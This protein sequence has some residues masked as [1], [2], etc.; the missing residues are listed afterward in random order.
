MALPTNLWL[1]MNISPHNTRQDYLDFWGD[2]QDVTQGSVYF[3]TQHY[4]ANTRQ[5]YADENPTF[6]AL[7]ARDS[8]LAH[9]VDQLIDSVDADFLA[10]DIANDADLWL[11]KS[12]A[13]SILAETSSGDASIA[14]W[15][16][17]DAYFDLRV[18]S[19]TSGYQNLR[20]TNH[21][22]SFT[23]Q[24]RSDD[25]STL[26]STPLYMD[27]NSEFTIVLGTLFSSGSVRDLG[28]VSYNWH[29][30]Y[31]S[32][33]VYGSLVPSSTL[34]Y[35]LGSFT[36]EWGIA[37][38]GN[39]YISNHV[40]GNLVPD[41]TTAFNLGDATHLWLN[42]YIQDLQISGDVY[43]DLIPNASA[44]YNLGNA[45]RFWSGAYIN[46][47]NLGNLITGHLTPSVPSTYNI[48]T[49]T[50]IWD[51]CHVNDL[52]V[53]TEVFTHLYPNGGSYSLGDATRQWFEVH[54]R[55]L[56]IYNLVVGN[57]NPSSTSYDLG[58]STYHWGEAHVED[59]YFYNEIYGDIIPHNS[60]SQYL[61]GS[62]H[63]WADI[64]TYRLYAYRLDSP[65]GTIR[66]E[67]VILEPYADNDSRLGTSG[68]RFFACYSSAY[69]SFTG[70]HDVALGDTVK[71][72]KIEEGMI[73]SS[74]GKVHVEDISNTVVEVDISK[75]PNDPCV[76]GVFKSKV[77]DLEET[78]ENKDS[79]MVKLAKTKQIWTV[80]SVGE[81]G[82]L[83]I[84]TEDKKPKNGD[85]L[86]TSSIPGYATV[87]ED[88]IFKSCTIAKVTQDIDW[89][90][91]DEYVTHKRK[92]YKKA[93]IAVTYHCG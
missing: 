72:K 21:S 55:N 47:L 37:Y 59:V 15:G 53:H 39:L 16:T 29:D 73:A 49:G 6:R 30:F 57:L 36:N 83:V 43:G 10:K 52:Y 79:F 32:G 74:V 85:L 8:A 80:N 66:L 77:S 81:G 20:I 50:N 60:A 42:A 1:D 41:S 48:G 70:A 62:G 67:S 11:S 45:F 63:E 76:Y 61:G 40:F 34:T 27:L 86:V 88:D 25:G 28:N 7:A 33:E 54:L 44:T 26:L 87:Q 56:Y 92:K 93:L 69:Y 3:Y 58:S 90:E 31:L 2:C 75:V 68:L 35:N 19:N 13:V 24:R 71:E 64:W 4:T 91:V 9:K 5:H 23:V 78:E 14:A 82:I 46:N 89:D 51:E 17:S 18:S 22:D 84:C 38:I 12:S 65:G